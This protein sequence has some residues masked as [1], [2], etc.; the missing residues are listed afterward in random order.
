MTLV[1]TMVLENHGV[2]QVLR[3]NKRVHAYSHCF[4][5]PPLPPFPVWISILYTRIQ[6]VKGGYGVIGGEK[7]WA[8]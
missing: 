5:L 4:A 6:C 1:K 7:A 8:R 2:T 3:N